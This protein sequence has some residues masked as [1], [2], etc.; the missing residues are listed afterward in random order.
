MA[1]DEHRIHR[2]ESIPPLLVQLAKASHRSRAYFA[3]VTDA[4]LCAEEF[5]ELLLRQSPARAI[6][7]GVTPGVNPVNCLGMGIVFRLAIV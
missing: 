1:C 7:D 5:R 6:S 4:N 2:I 3:R